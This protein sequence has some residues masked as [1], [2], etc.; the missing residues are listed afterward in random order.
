MGRFTRRNLF[1]L[2]AAGLAAACA[3]GGAAAF[4]GTAAFNH[5]V[6]SGDATQGAVIV[7]TRVTAD[8]PEAVPVDWTVA[9][10]SGFKDIVKQGTFTT[11][12]DRDHTV[13]VDVTG[14]QPGQT[15]YYRFNVGETVSPAGLTRTLPGGDV[16]AYRMA[17]VSCSNWP[18]G[19]F[20]VYREVAMRDD[21]DAVFH[22]GDYIYEYGVDGY[23]GEVG[24]SIGRNHEP[25]VEI[26]DL[27]AYR[28][29]HA[30]YKSDP[31]LQAAH[32]AAPWFCTWDDHESADNS[33]RTGAENHQPE[34]E[35]DWS[36]RKA[37]AVQAYLEWMPVRDP[38][39]GRARE[40]IYHTA[41]VGDLATLFMLESRLIGR[42]DEIHYDLVRA[43]S[44][45]E[46]PKVLEGILA[47]VNSEDRTMWGPE[48]ETFV[49]QQLAA[50]TKAGK[51]W[52]VLVNQV[53]M[54][55]V[56]APDFTKGLTPAEIEELPPAAK[57][58]SQLAP[59]GAPYNL[60][61]WDGYA[62]ARTRLY[63]AA[64]D[65][66]ARLIV[67]TGDTHTAFANALHDAD[68]KVLG[69]EFACTSVSSPGLGAAIPLPDVG[70]KMA[71]A[72]ED[73]V[74]NNCFD[75]GY[76]M[77]T[78]TPDAVKGEFVKVSTILSQDYE[79]STDAVFTAARTDAGMGPVTRQA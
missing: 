22:V 74:W 30:Q 33:Y 34:T 57:R 12:P 1:T 10:D 55:H 8:P 46:A 66:G 4:N 54:A 6:A 2:G 78:L 40:A 17:V 70:D 48:Q 68:G 50:S 14:L 49:N 53:I 51:P 15:Y 67:L 44:P 64:R 25:P 7:W 27:A 29:R 18:F 13:K 32:A 58:L 26:T 35:G 16:S 31:D 73:V 38:A 19:F 63:R 24:K 52:Q 72:S 65:A 79:A 76:T 61:A 60:D 42:S 36:A 28:T 20:N 43:A 21:V 69:A 23:G 39:A 5:G 37:Q 47:Q 9:R 3:K 41:D 77:V 75:H 62:A 56:K 71:A 11:G 59:F 45:E